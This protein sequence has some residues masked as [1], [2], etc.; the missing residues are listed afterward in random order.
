M[1][2]TAKER[3]FTVSYVLFDSCYSS[4]DNLKTI[5]E[6]GWHFFTRLKSNRL[7]NPDRT[8]NVPVSSIEIP[9][10]G[11]IVHLKGFGMVKV[12]RTVSR[13]GDVDYWATD[14]I[15]MN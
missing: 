9:P 10:E 13:E 1:M 15:D 5:R 14:D 11:R 12:F 7:V 2:K 3:C 8:Y 4:L 6:Y